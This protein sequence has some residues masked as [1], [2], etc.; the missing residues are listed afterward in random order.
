MHIILRKLFS[1]WFTFLAI[2]TIHSLVVFAGRPPLVLGVRHGGG[3]GGRGRGGQELEQRHLLASAL[4][5]ITIGRREIADVS[6]FSIVHI[7]RFLSAWLNH[8]I[9]ISLFSLN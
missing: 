4:R 6:P 9:S 8:I 7:T 1:S 3:G 5:D 2:A